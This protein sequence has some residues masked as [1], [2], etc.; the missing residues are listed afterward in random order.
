MNIGIDLKP[1]FSG[2]KYRG[3]GMYSRELISE[4][5]KNGKDM[6]YHF[7]NLYGDYLGD[8]VINQH[9]FLYQYYTGPKIL[10][11]GER[12]LFDNDLTEE[13]IE[14]SVKHFLEQSKIDI[15]LFTSP[16]EYGNFYKAEWF[17][18]VYTV[19][20]LYDL[21]PM[22]FPEQC[23]FD[24]VYKANY[25]KSI[26]FIKNLDLLLAISESAKN[27]AVKLLGI[28][29]SKIVV[30]HAGINQEFRKLEKIEHKKIKEK[31]NISKPFIL[32]AGGIDF[33]KN[34]EG[35][36]EAYSLLPINIK[37]RYQF[38]ITGKMAEETK[39][40]FIKVSEKYNIKDDIVYTGYVS[41]EDL[42]QLYNITELLVFP[43]LYE[44]FGLPVLEAMA[45]GTRVVTSN[46]S[47]LIEI[48][49]NYAT[50]VDAS[51][52]KKIMKGIKYVFDNP[53]KTLELAENSIEYAKSYTWEKVAYKTL[54]AIEKR[55]SN[56]DNIQEKYENLV[57]TEKL[58]D[59]IT[60]LFAKN[61]IP[62]N[63]VEINGITESLILLQNNENSNII[64]GNTR[65]LYD[66]TVVHE[67]L[68][69]N[70][71]T[72]IGRVCKELFNSLKEKCVVLP[73]ILSKDLKNETQFE[74]ISM[75][76][77]EKTKEKITLME[78]DI[79]FM[80]EFQIRGVQISKE[81]PY[82]NEFRQK[83]LSCYAVI[84]DIL[85]LQFPEYFE[86]KTS[87]NFKKYIDELLNN[88]TGILTDS[89]AVADD[90]IEYY[91]KNHSNKLVDD[92]KIGYF[93]LGQDTFKEKKELTVGYEL[94][95]FM[96]DEENIYLMVGTIEP[97]KGHK[98]VYNTFKKMWKE[99]FEG[100]LCIIGHIGW[101][102]EKFVEEL[103]N[104]KE[105]RDKILFIEGASDSELAFA[106][107]NSDALIQ[108][109]VGEGFGLPLIEAGYYNLPII[110]SNIPVFHEVSDEN[111][112]FFDR[113]EEGLQEKIM[114]FEK[115]IETNVI[116]E[117]KNIKHL[118][119]SEV[120]DKVY[121]MIVK[122]KEWYVNIKKNGTI[123]EYEKGVIYE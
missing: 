88:Y 62:F 105:F 25:E 112:I 49:K 23:L 76:N 64:E 65:I 33:K 111:A 77:F 66:M 11:V 40:H 19:G 59:N 15:M 107:K 38:V 109:S 44:G 71:S 103:K 79:F 80:P 4:I 122:D 48:A 58:L 13:I 116:P 81:H 57:V 51:S 10:D 21:I 56:R 110:C 27:D 104:P 41:N 52:P 95:K 29:E 6:K 83:G 43:S 8:P 121:N 98:L 31:Y 113:N 70:Y 53:I 85:P 74:L 117:S 72:G 39:N 24:P 2:A 82:A 20:I 17:K 63:Q 96:D 37:N 45:C 92:L 18:N 12:Q 50:L 99:G 7:L 101:K 123:E 22:I 47:S 86:E 46:N 108:A 42:I 28:D 26:E 30:I 35:L 75:E 32:F 34:I 16:N 14:K 119:W 84:Y 100:K 97:R 91:K 115:N 89:R 61:K 60:L 3:I 87:Q 120:A 5:L 118:T 67:W 55:I 94:S 106:Y 9:S 78:N 69:N 68:K 114:F 102:M 1:F 73:V 54:D 93:H 36:I 90:V